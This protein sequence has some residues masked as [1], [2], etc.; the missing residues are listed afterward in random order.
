ME[1]KNPPHPGTFVRVEII[2][3]RGL[4]VASASEVL[5]VTRAALSAFLNGRAS[6]SAEMAIRFE[7]A[8][9]YP[10]DLLMRMQNYYDIQ[11]ARQRASEITVNGFVPADATGESPA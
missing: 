4:T 11:Q 5:G 1:M 2:E 3:A 6:L 10:M 8:F 9:G 7:K